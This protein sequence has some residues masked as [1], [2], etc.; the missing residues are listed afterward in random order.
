M[1]VSRPLQK[2]AAAEHAASQEGTQASLP[3]ED[4]Q[5]EPHARQQ[6][7]A[8]TA[9]AEHAASREGIQASLPQEDEQTQPHAR[10]GK[11]PANA[12]KGKGQN[13]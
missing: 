4:V 7:P 10:R 12:A 9:A 13:A 8:E 3:Q 1:P 5:T 11:A 6:A 2:T